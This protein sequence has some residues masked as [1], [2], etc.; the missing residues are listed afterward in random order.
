MKLHN[1]VLA[2]TYLLGQEYTFTILAWQAHVVATT[3]FHTQASACY[4][5][6]LLDFVILKL[7]FAILKLFFQLSKSIISDNYIINLKRA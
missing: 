1:A 3:S 4:F 7:D 6:P 2:L 5:F